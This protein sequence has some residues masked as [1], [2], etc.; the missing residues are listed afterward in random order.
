MR[1]TAI[2]TA[3]AAPDVKQRLNAAGGMEPFASTPAEFAALIRRDYDK[4][5]AVVKAVGVRVD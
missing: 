1:R 5:G 3:L 4:Y 2:S